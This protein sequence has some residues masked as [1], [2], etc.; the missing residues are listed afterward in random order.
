MYGTPI[1]EPVLPEWE[2]REQICEVGRWLWHRQYVEANGGNITYRLQDGRIL[3]TPTMI[4]KGM[5][6]PDDLVTLDLQGNQTG[7]KRKKTSEILVHLQ[8]LRNRPDVRCV[9]HCHPPHAT[10]FAITG[11]ALPKCVHPEQEIFLGEVPVAP[12][13]TP[14]TQ[15]VADT[16]S[17]FIKDFNVYLLASHGAV[18]AGTGILDAYW[19][20]EIVEAYC[21]LIILAQAIGGASMLT[22]G[23]MDEL[24]QIKKNL[25]LHDRR[26]ADPS[27]SS[28]AVQSPAPEPPPPMRPPCGCSGEPAPAGAPPAASGAG[29]APSPEVIRQVTEAVL[30]KLQG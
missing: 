19:K 1:D 26:I 20:T 30:R 29:V 17:P 14:G 27:A 8:I 10:A 21:R 3:A 7:G 15:R 6:K 16:L 11:K 23:Q 24:L 22:Q 12:Y 9:I 13:E 28:C 4:S 25:G 5:M 18:A 2:A